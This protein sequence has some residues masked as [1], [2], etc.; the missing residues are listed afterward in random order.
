[1]TLEDI[2]KKLRNINTFLD[3]SNEEVIDYAGESARGCEY[4]IK[5]GKTWADISEFIKELETESLS[6]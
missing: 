3:L 5:V 4:A 6:D 1:M 2:L